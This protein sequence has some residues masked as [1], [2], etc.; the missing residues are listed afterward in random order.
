MECELSRTILDEKLL[1]NMFRV[2]AA[3]KLESAFSLS[4]SDS[5][6]T[7]ILLAATKQSWLMILDDQS[8]VSLP[9][10]ADIITDLIDNHTPHGLSLSLR[11]ISTKLRIHQPLLDHWSRLQ[12]SSWTVSLPFQLHIL[13]L[14]IT[15]MDTL[16]H[17]LAFYCAPFHPQGVDTVRGGCVDSSERWYDFA[18]HG[19]QHCTHTHTLSLLWSV[20]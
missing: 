18:R 11:M 12:Y 15:F 8:P 9:R 4:L 14:A 20:R 7:Y 16:L 6:A 3:P 17:L 5:C 2:A 10:G 13:S 1:I 19:S